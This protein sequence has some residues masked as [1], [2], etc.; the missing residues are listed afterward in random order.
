LHH[1]ASTS[2]SRSQPPSRFPVRTTS[3]ARIKLSEDIASDHELH[4]S[5]LVTIKACEGDWVLI[6]RRGK[7][8]RSVRWASKLGHCTFPADFGDEA[9]S[10]ISRLIAHGEIYPYSNRHLAAISAAGSR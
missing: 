4:K 10:S 2:R 9:D 8:F 7:E 3:R 1:A 5:T 6:A